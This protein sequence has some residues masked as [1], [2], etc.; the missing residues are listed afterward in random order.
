M[1]QKLYFIISVLVVFIFARLFIEAE[2]T[3]NWRGFYYSS[4]HVLIVALAGLIFLR[5]STPR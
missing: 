3:D 2:A 5:V 1:N 4:L